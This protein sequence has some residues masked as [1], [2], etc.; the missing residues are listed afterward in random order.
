MFIPLGYHCNVTFL[1]QELN[2]KKET[3]LFEWLETQQLQYITDI[4]NSIKE[5]IDTSIIKGNDKNLYVLNPLV[6]TFHYNIE[7]YK[8]IFERR[9]TR[10][11]DTIKNSNELI[12]VRINRYKAFTTE[13]EINNFCNAIYSINSSV[14]IKF[15]LINT[16]DSYE[17]YSR[18]DEKNI[19]NLDLIQRYFLYEDCIRDGKDEYLHHNYTI[20]K[21]FREYL[22]D[23]GYFVDE[24]YVENFTE[25][26][27]ARDKD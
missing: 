18:L 11:L 12:F 19:P 5:N 14:K 10:F 4:I 3:G 1:A 21:L 23:I 8:I 7:E 20:R 16:I 13:D 2:I 6:Y 9:A 15:L 17:N 25:N 26:S 27:L 22:I 24:K